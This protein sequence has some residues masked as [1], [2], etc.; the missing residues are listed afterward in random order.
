MMSFA[1]KHTKNAQKTTSDDSYRLIVSFISKGAGIDSQTLAALESLVTTFSNKD[2]FLV[3]YDKITWG[4]EGE[5]DYCFKM[6]GM[7]ASKQEEFVKA[8]KNVTKDSQ[9]VLITENAVNS[10]KK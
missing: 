7:K 4:K 9:Q 5:F 2:G 1:C 10:H 3:K 6:A 8:V